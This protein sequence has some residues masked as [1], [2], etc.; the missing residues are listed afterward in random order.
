MARRG[1]NVL[2]SLVLAAVILALAQAFLEDYGVLAGW[3]ASLRRGLQWTGFAFDLLFTVEFLIRARLAAGGRRLDRY[4]GP[5]R[6]WLDFL[7]SA[8]PLMFCSGPLAASLL[9]GPA[10][11]PPAAGLLYLPPLLRAMRIARFLRLLRAARL[12]GRFRPGPR[13]MVRRHVGVAAAIALSTSALAF[14][15]FGILSRPLGLASTAEALQRRQRQTAQYLERLRKD[16]AMFA[17]ALAALAQTDESLL[18]H[19]L[20][21]VTRFSRYDDAYYAERFA[22]GD[23]GYVREGGQELFFDLRPETRRLAGEN[24]A[25]LALAVLLALA[26]LLRYAPH[27]SLTV[28]EPLEHMRRGLEEPSFDRL[29]DIPERYREDEVFRLAE[30]YNRRFL[31]LKSARGGRAVRG[32][33]QP[34]EGDAGEA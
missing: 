22:P 34:K 32:L 5:E 19:R 13:S 6:G 14:V 18:I 27:F 8:P 29:V 23:Y 20:D 26:Y 10:G 2:E 7:A 25:C 30:G 21:G 31:A 9:L 17:G 4:L 28:T 16:P 3:P 15:L 33:A 11:W 24:L 12:F 1:A